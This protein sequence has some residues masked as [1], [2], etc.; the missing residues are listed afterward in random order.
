MGFVQVSQWEQSI[1]RIA[2]LVAWKDFDMSTLDDEYCKDYDYW[3]YS[4]GVH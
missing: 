3:E 4:F 1:A 2:P